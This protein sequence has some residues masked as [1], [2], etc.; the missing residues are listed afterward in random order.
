M[1]SGVTCERV[2]NL[3]YGGAA[4]SV[5]RCYDVRGSKLF[6]LFP[7]PPFFAEICALAFLVNPVEIPGLRRN[8]AN[9]FLLP[10]LL[11]KP[12]SSSGF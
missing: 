2:F 3:I 11:K 7:R 8:A 10:S 4:T 9:S 12:F 6:F 5:L 1:R